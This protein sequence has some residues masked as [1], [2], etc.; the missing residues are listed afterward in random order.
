MV[1]ANNIIPESTICVVS[2]ITKNT[3]D[4]AFN[5]GMKVVKLDPDQQHCDNATENKNCEKL[6]K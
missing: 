6:S 1:N 5:S 4:T 2:N 3:N